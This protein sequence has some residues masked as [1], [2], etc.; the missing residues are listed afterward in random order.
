VRV[1]SAGVDSLR[2]CRPEREFRVRDLGER[3]V[4]KCVE[5]IQNATDCEK[6]KK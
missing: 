4:S 1:W 2:S 3:S 6:R 5:R